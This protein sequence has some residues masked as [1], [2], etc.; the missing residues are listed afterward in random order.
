MQYRHW[1]RI[2]RASPSVDV[3]QDDDTGG[4]NVPLAPPDQTI[5]DGKADWQDQGYRVPRTSTG[6]SQVAA[7]GVLFLQQRG[8]A[9]KI[10]PGDAV[11]LEHPASR[12]YPGGHTSDGSVTR[13]QTLDDSLL[14]TINKSAP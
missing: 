9:A 7:D 2:V 11:Q 5:Y 6:E 12:A 13:V 3:V 14:L 8:M 1:A 10:Q 4:V